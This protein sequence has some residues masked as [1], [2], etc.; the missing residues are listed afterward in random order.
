MPGMDGPAL[1]REIRR[2]REDIKVI[3]IS[4]CSEDTIRERIETDEDLSFLS[5]PFS[6]KQLA[7]AVKDVL[8]KD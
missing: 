1:V 7:S 8:M 2:S 5:K 4:G 3:C 6:L